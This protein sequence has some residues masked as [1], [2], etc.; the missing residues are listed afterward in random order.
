MTDKNPNPWKRRAVWMSFVGYVLISV[1]VILY[2]VADSGKWN[3]K[4]DDLAQNFEHTSDSLNGVN[5]FL[6]SLIV[7]DDYYF[8]GEMQLSLEQLEAL[9]TTVKSNPFFQQRILDRINILKEFLEAPD[10]SDTRIR[11]L[12]MVIA[13]KEFEIRKLRGA[14]DSIFGIFQDTLDHFSNKI[15]G[16]KSELSE[17]QKQ[18]A[19]K[20]RIKVLTF[21]TAKGAKI[22]YLGE[23]KD[24]KA[25]GGGVGVWSTGSIYRGEWKDNKRHGK[26]NYEWPNG[27]IYQGEYI[28]DKREGQGAY[29]WPSGEKYDGEWKDDKRNG[30]GILYDLDGNIQYQ[31]P[32]E[33]DKIKN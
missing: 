3:K 19:T 12:L 26:G 5:S 10:T 25:N 2:V 4:Y 30:F 18:L 22:H 31:G 32:W 1:I 33:N 21:N 16:L 17:K 13:D 24:E 9:E 8:D 6:I 7:A 23:V 11:T 29:I 20:D 27:H 28:D 14:N 15:S